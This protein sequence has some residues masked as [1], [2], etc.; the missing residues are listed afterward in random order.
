MYNTK[1][2]TKDN[3]DKKPSNNEVFKSLHVFY[4]IW[5]S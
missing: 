4:Q 3:Y 5:F 1:I 2:E